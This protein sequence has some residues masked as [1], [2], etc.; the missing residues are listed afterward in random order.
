MSRLVLVAALLLAAC[1]NVGGLDRP[2]LGDPYRVES[3]TLDGDTLRAVVQ[4]GGGCATHTFERQSQT[5]GERWEVW[6][7]HDANGDLCEA[8]LTD[9]LAA[10]VAF[11]PATAIPLV[12]LTLSG[13]DVL[14]RAHR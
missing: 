11:L 5:D 6:F 3:A 2:D 10:D 13:D 9:T 4:Y 7:V 14:L 1:D 8:L 12:L